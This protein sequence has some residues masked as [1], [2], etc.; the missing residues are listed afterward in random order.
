MIQENANY[1]L[2]VRY[3]AV[4]VSSVIAVAGWIFSS[5]INT[6][7]FKRNETSKLKDRISS[8]IES[9]F[10]S[11]E[12]KVK[13]RGVKETELDDLISGRMSLIELHLKH[14]EKKIN[15]KLISDEQLTKIRSEPYDYLLSANGDFKKKLS[16]LRFNTLELIEDNYTEWYFRNSTKYVG[17]R[18]LKIFKSI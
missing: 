16:E 14:L 5:Y 18:F 10:D 2:D 15:I 11:L 7:T 17:M 6:R 9:F 8:M 12:D 3:A 1:V 13:S 4:I